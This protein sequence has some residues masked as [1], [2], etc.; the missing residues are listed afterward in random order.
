MPIISIS[1]NKEILSELD[2]LQKT[3]GF[4]GRSEAVRAGIRTF[5]SEE[6]QKL[7][8]TGNIHAILLVVHNDEF[9]HVVSGIK[10]NFEDLITTH[11]H[12]KIEGEKCME[13]F[14]I[15]GDAERVSTITK[16]FQVNKNMDTVKLVT[17]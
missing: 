1:L 4:S 13:L 11:L 3:M 2:K 9:D 7:E 17:L 12:S 15:D 8:L 5:V 6:K 14:V 10:H 16:D